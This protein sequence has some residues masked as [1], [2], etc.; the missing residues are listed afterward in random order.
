MKPRMPANAQHSAI[1]DRYDEPT[2]SSVGF[3]CGDCMKITDHAQTLCA[4]NCSNSANSEPRSGMCVVSVVASRTRLSNSYTECAFDLGVISKWPQRRHSL[5]GSQ[6]TKIHRP[7]P[8]ETC[9]LIT[10]VCETI[11]GPLGAVRTFYSYWAY[12][13]W[14]SMLPGSTQATA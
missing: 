12:A 10:A 9:R 4:E 5:L 8:E 3:P 7:T 1:F 2:L 13:V 6:A 11:Q 14:L